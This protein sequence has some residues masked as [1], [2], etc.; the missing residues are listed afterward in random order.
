[1]PHRVG[2][3]IVPGADPR[4]PEYFYVSDV[5]LDRGLKARLIRTTRTD[6]DLSQKEFA[7]RFRFPIARL[8]DREQARSTPPRYAVAYIKLIANP[9][10]VAQEVA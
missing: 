10:L 2:P 7:R 5:A 3:H 9:K 1:M 8:R 6:L 4:N